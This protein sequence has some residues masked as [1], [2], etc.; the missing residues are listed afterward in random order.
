MQVLSPWFNVA[1]E[2]T[3]KLKD[4]R[5][6]RVDVLAIPKDSRFSR[7]AFAIEEKRAQKMTDR[8]AARIRQA[9]DY[10]G[11]IATLTGSQITM[12]FIDLKEFKSAHPDERR[13]CHVMMRVAHQFFVGGLYADKGRLRLSSGP[14]DI[15]RECISDETGENWPGRAIERLTNMRQSAGGRRH[16]I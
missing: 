13:D 1:E 9:S 10:V 2:V 15:W 8:L 3:V 14:D 4:G 16:A 11:S 5:F 12:V 7:F 6:G